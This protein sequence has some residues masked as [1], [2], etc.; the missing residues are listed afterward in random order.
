MIYYNIYKEGLIAGAKDKLV[1]TN[2]YYLD[3]YSYAE[4]AVCETWEHGWYAGK[5]IL[6]KHTKSR[7]IFDA[8]FPQYISI[9]WNGSSVLSNNP[10]WHFT[11]LA[12]RNAASVLNWFH[13]TIV[14]G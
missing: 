3:K 4:D 9:D 8:G 13:N 12:A 6:D 7:L 10:I 11:K 14:Y 1:S 5:F 2:P